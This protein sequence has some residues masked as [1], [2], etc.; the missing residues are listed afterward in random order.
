M[1]EGGVVSKEGEREL[2]RIAR[3][4]VEAAASGRPDPE[5]GPE[6]LPEL[7]EHLGA[8][9]TLH[10]RGRLRGCIGTFVA[11]KPVWQVVVEMARSA[12]LNDPRFTPL[13][14][15]ELPAV[16]IE[17]SVLSPLV[18]TDDPLSL[19]PGVHG[20]YIKRG[21]QSG[22]YLPQVATEF[23]MSKEEFLSSCC[24][25]KAGLAPDAWKDPAT[26]VYLYTAQVFG[27]KEAGDEGTGA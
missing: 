20:V 7:E 22:T 18:K 15:A 16:D 27:E 5:R 4:V 3:R 25:H 1:S 19:E 8:F 13:T 23:G 12:A 26:E 6:G 2:L 10:Q 24:S 11:R 9:V 21:W 17:I 14:E